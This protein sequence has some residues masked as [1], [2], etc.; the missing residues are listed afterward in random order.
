MYIFAKIAYSSSH[1]PV[2]KWHP[3]SNYWLFKSEPETYSFQT[4]AKEKKTTWNGV[5]NFQARNFLRQ[6]KKGDFAFI[7]HSGKEKAVV[8]VCRIL[9]DGYLELDPK[10]P[11]EWTQLDVAYALQLKS[12]VSLAMIKKTPALKTMPLIKHTRLSCMPVDEKEFKTILE[13]GEAW[14]AFQKLK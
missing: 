12:P 10:K 13:M 9:K 11:G 5:R 14:D 4:L 7:Y 8:G 2:G 6:C 1:K 3:M